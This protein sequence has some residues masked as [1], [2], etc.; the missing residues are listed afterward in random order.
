[1]KRLIYLFL[2]L[3]FL[4]HAQ[5]DQ[6]VHFEDGLSWTAIQAKAKAENKYIF[7]DCYTSWCGPCKYMASQVFP[8]P[9]AGAYFN[10]KFISVSV[11]LDTSKKDNDDI[12]KWY[13]DAHTL[14]A[15]YNVRAYPTFLIF[16]PDGHVV[17]RTVGSSQTAADFITRVKDAFDPEKQYYTLL[18]QYRSGKRDSAFL[19]KMTTAAW[20]AYDSK[21]APTILNEYLATQKDLFTVGN[22]SLIMQYTQNTKDRGFNILLN[23]PEKVDKALGAGKAEQK[24]LG[25]VIAE[26]LYP[27]FRSGGTPQWTALQ[28]QVAKKYPAL[29]DEVIARGQVVYYQNTNN[30]DG[31]QGAIV[32]YMKKYG[33]LATAEELNEY[34]W[35]VFQHCPDMTCVSEALDWSKRSF[36]DEQNPAYMDTYANILYKMGKKD[37]AI[38]YEEKALSLVGEEGKQTYQQTIDKMKKGEK[39]W[40]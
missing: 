9:E 15:Q 30:W 20:A 34:A 17:H 26:E 16:A 6:G 27:A 39:T 22:L 4:S 24:V 10:D 7:M 1:M 2:F 25:I 12:K 3:P 31:F 14:A 37:E 21:N 18:E 38:A 32:G 8:K 19:R 5:Q 13:V 33:S 29:A 23:N 40:D 36:K 28:Q 35:S 11:Q